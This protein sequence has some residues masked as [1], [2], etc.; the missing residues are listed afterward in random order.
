MVNPALSARQAQLEAEIASLERAALV[1]DRACLPVEA[2]PPPAAEPPP[3][4]VDVIDDRR[5]QA[6]GQSG[7]LTITLVWDSTAD[8]DLYLI[9]PG[10][11]TINYRNR[12]ACGGQLDL[13]A[14]INRRTSTPVE[15][16]F[17]RTGAPQGQ[18]RIRVNMYDSGPRRVNSQNFTVR[19]QMGDRQETF[20]GTVRPRRRDWTQSFEYRG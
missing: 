7:E 1:A 12:S 10:G 9:C 17:F 19:V 14:N 3:P 5:R 16:I 6:G 4:P 11:Q 20:Q 18:Y 15:N 2:P 13:D 8:L